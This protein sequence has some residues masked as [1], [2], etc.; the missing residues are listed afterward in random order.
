MVVIAMPVGRVVVV[1]EEKGRRRMGQTMMHQV[2]KICSRSLLLLLLFDETAARSVEHSKPPVLE[3][4]F[5]SRSVPPPP[6]PPLPHSHCLR[7]TILIS[8]S[9]VMNG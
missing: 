8:I 2:H 7:S 9:L 4:S 3:R 5:G 1:V 6:P